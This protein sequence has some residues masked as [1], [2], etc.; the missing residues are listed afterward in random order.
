MMRLGCGRRL[1]KEDLDKLLK[2]GSMEDLVDENQS[3]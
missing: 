3:D 1:K 2:P